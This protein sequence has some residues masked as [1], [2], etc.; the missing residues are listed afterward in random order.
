MFG[1]GRST[2]R[3]GLAIVVASATALISAAELTPATAQDP[4]QINLDY[5]FYGNGIRVLTLGFD[6]S[7]QDNNYSVRYALKT[8]GL[9]SLFAAG[10]TTAI[11][12]GRILDDSIRAENFE[13]V[14][15]GKK[16]R[17]EITVAWDGKQTPKTVR[18]YDLGKRKS[19]AIAKVLKPDFP[20]PISAML[21]ATLFDAGK[22]CQ[23][24]FTVYDGKHVFELNFSY[25]GRDN[26]LPSSSGVYSG[27]AYKCKLTYKPIAGLSKKK[28]KKARKEPQP[29]FTIWMA[30]FAAPGRDDGA[31]LIPVRATG[32][33]KW[34]N[35]DIYLRK[36]KA[37]GAP[38]KAI[39]LANK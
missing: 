35:L 23:S 30:P 37:T 5:D 26:V 32:R 28:M 24:S 16:G 6:A 25:I 17:R 3:L 22:P 4:E 7:M 21:Q 12:K 8:K 34:A 9:A 39:T 15:K 11:S 33:L 27:P 13:S 10:T 29:P 1:H 14:S 38:L 2:P 19:G 31:L 18:S 20:D 36:G